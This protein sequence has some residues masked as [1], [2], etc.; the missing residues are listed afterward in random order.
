MRPPDHEGLVIDAVVVDEARPLLALDQGGVQA[1]SRDEAIFIHERWPF[2]RDHRPV[3]H[4][5]AVDAV[6][7]LE[8]ANPLVRF[9][10]GDTLTLNLSE[11][12]QETTH[13][14]L[15]FF[16]ADSIPNSSGRQSHRRAPLS[17]FTL[18][19]RAKSEKSA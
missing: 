14:F 4:R 2:V 13:R 17:L 6:V 16:F 9:S 3:Q 11:I 12:H 7:A 5:L 15:S 8:L 1:G 10:G 19:Y 18:I